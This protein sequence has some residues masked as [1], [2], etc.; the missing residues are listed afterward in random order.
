LSVSQDLLKDYYTKTM[1][2]SILD[3]RV[4]ASIVAEYLPQVAQA[5]INVAGKTC[6]S[7]STTGGSMLQALTFSWFICIYSDSVGVVDIFMMA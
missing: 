5:L 2:G 1:R 6:G 3:Q 4:F 7:A